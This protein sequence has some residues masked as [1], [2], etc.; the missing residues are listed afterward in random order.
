MALPPADGDS[1]VAVDVSLAFDP[2]A[3]TTTAPTA[4]A[5]TSIVVDR[6]RQRIRDVVI[7]ARS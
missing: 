4:T 2:H 3:V 5:A 7:D 6:R 1:V